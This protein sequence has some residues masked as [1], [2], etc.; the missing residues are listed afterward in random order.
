MYGQL[1]AGERPC[2]RRERDELGVEPVPP[3][4]VADLVGESG[5]ER[6]GVAGKRARRPERLQVDLRL[7]V[8]RAVVPVDESR[9]V[10]VEPQAE[11]Q[12]VARDGVWGSGPVERR[13]RRGSLSHP[14]VIAEPSPG[15]VP[16]PWPGPMPRSS[17]TNGIPCRSTA[18]RLIRSAAVFASAT[19]RTY[20]ASSSG[21]I[22]R[23]RT[24]SFG[25]P[26]ISH[27][28]W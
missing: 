15:S 19:S 1:P 13:R 20:A 10:L 11:Q 22:A 28:R 8:R 12:V 4:V 18:S 25:L 3:V 9:D 2:L 26:T 14:V 5:A 6:V 27:D 23:P 17:P 7:E 16:I 24:M 21:V